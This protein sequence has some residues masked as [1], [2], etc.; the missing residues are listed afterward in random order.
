MCVGN[1][2]KFALIVFDFWRERAAVNFVCK[3]HRKVLQRRVIKAKRDRS[4]VSINVVEAV[5]RRIFSIDEGS[6]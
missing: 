3:L 5:K 6:R 2:P 1:S 4:S